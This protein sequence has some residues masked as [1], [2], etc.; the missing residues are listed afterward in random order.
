MKKDE[1]NPITRDQLANLNENCIEIITKYIEEHGMTV[2]AFSKKCGVHP[3]Q[4]YLFL[5]RLRGL[6]LTTMQRIGETIQ[7]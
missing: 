6:N 4:M 1:A 2:H 7:D 5:N 3:N